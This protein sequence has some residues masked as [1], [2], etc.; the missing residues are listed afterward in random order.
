MTDRA[1]N[2]SF[3]PIIIGDKLFDE[4]LTLR[5]YFAGQALSGILN[6]EP[7]AYAVAT[8]VATTAAE[9]SYFIADAMLRERE[10][11]PRP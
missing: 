10:K 11:D 3:H 8:E 1:K 7:G 9:S 6:F 4:G 2:E 5:D